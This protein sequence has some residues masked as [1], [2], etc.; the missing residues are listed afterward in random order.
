MRSRR[1]RG[2]VQPPCRS[3]SEARTRASSER[4]SR[5]RHSRKKPQIAQRQAIRC[6]HLGHGRPP[7][8]AGR[9]AAGGARTAG[10]GGGGLIAAAGGGAGRATGGGRITGGGG[11]GLA[12]AGG[13]GGGRVATGGGVGLVTAGGG[14]AGLTTTGGGEGR[15]I[16]GCDGC[17]V[18]GLTCGPPI[19]GAP[20]A[21]GIGWPPVPG[22]GL[23]KWRAG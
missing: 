16:C 1:K 18:C 6:R 8:F 9:A 21:G 17:N 23:P 15:R 2:R 19:L 12:I 22:S 14:P 3:N 5:P 7:Q 11:A 20:L 13:G 4:A 10:G